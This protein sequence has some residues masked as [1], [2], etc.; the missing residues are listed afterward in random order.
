MRVIVNAASVKEG[1]PRVVL[2]QLV[3][4]MCQLRKDI[5]WSVAV[6]PSVRLR[7][8]ERQDVGLVDVGD[9]DSNPLGVLRWY[10]SAL[11]AAV[12]RL[13]ADLVFS[14][15]NY[16]PLRRL[17]VPTVLLVQHAGHFSKQFD[18]LYRRYLQRPD[19]IIG[20]R[21]KKQWVE[22][23]VRTAT[24][25]TV[26]TEALADAVAERTGR[27]R[28]RIHA[29]AHGP[30][31][32][33]PTPVSRGSPSG[34]SVRIGY[35]TKW[36]V[37]KNFEV[38]FDAAKRLIGQGRA[39]RIVLTLAEHLPENAGVVHRARAMGLGD[40]IE[41]VGEVDAAAISKLYDSFDIFAFPS[42]VESF[43]FPLVEAMAKG[44]PIVAADTPSNRELAGEAGLYFAPTDAGS[45]ARIV[46][47]LIDNATLREARA[48]AAF[49]RAQDFSWKRAAEQTLALFDAALHTT[50]PPCPSG[51][52][53]RD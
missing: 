34:R 17:A 28:A 29:I 32:V 22:R 24:E 27:P 25:L 7:W 36:G 48:A 5:T 3:T 18:D 14:V 12:K 51:E 6:H 42:L 21:L 40:V 23:S 44:L 46:G 33:T 50:R 13:N 47:E 30:G 9:I 52:I 38:L 4:H 10:E 2:D 43:G 31:T 41:N 49:N 15:T 26:Q 37:Q 16:L 39:I 1:G 8:D 19:R 20:W 53:A 35:V 11:P 45:L